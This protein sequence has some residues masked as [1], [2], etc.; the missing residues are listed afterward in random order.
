MSFILDALKKSEQERQKNHVPDLKTS[1]EGV[2]RNGWMRH[3]RFWF[4]LVALFLNAGLILYWLWPSQVQPQAEAQ[5]TEE[6]PPVSHSPAPLSPAASEE[7]P[8]AAAPPAVPPPPPRIETA[9]PRPVPP[10]AQQPVT[11]V[12]QVS[13][14]I[15]DMASLSPEDRRRLPEIEISLHFYSSNP[16]LSMVRINGRNLREGDR[17]A[18]GLRLEQITP[19]GVVLDHEGTRFRAGNF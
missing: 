6:N 17:V 16:T 19:T 18:P 12:A 15:P 10:T 1:H 2:S 14:K 8:V 13:S 9:P 7:A 4:L 5:I 3:L 11:P